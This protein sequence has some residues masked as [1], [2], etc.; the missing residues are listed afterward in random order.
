MLSPATR[1]CCVVLCD[2]H[3]NSA[4]LR[5]STGSLCVFYTLNPVFFSLVSVLYVMLLQLLC[6]VSWVPL[7]VT[8]EGDGRSC[9]P[10]HTCPRHCCSCI[11]IPCCV[12]YCTCWYTV[13]TLR[14]VFLTLYVR[15]W[16][17]GAVFRPVLHCRTSVPLF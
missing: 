13:V 1:V 17:T 12:H 8:H 9:S 16:S 15:S 11:G 2:S 10:T 5:N 7:H 3:G 4:E 14:L 6:V